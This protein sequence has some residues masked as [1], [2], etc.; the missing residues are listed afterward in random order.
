MEVEEPAVHI[1]S[2]YEANF[3]AKYPV[4]HVS[5]LLPEVNSKFNI[6]G[7]R[8]TGV[9]LCIYHI[10]LLKYKTIVY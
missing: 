6:P 5:K 2:Q 3:I 7:A 4:V 1:V 9:G 10:A 8:V